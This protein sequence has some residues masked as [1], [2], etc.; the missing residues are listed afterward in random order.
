M[1]P[2]V[3]PLEPTPAG[4]APAPAP[5]TPVKA[6]VATTSPSPSPSPVFILKKM[7]VNAPVFTPQ[8]DEDVKR[9]AVR[10]TNQAGEDVNLAELAAVSA[11]AAPANAIRLANPQPVG[12]YRRVA[13][14]PAA[15]PMG[16]PS[17][18]TPHRVLA[19][20]E[21]NMKDST[22][23]ECGAFIKKELLTHQK[24][25]GVEGCKGAPTWL[26][27]K[28][29]KAF[30]VAL[31]SVYPSLFHRITTQTSILLFGFD[32]S[33]PTRLISCLFH[34][35]WATYPCLILCY[36]FALIICSWRM[37]LTMMFS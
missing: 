20:L 5:V 32:I 35:L 11:K 16:H 25:W 13:S 36:W 34:I 3:V 21:T 15:G 4:T 10:I 31:H 33:F 9:V 1:L 17:F 18:E 23:A 12:R 7:D 37:I 28:T 24:N 29:L 19:Y 14:V 6:R 2:G 30:I 27:R 8:K 26:L 22:V